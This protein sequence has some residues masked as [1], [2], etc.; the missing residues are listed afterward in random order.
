MS[1][2]HENPLVKICALIGGDEYLKITHSYLTQNMQLMKK[3]HTRAG[4][5]INIVQQ[6]LL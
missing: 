4:L 6:G 5:R 3:L 1:V 2:E